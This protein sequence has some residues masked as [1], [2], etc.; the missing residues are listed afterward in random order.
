MNTDQW[1]GPGEYHM[2]RSASDSATLLAGVCRHERQERAVMGAAAEPAG[3]ERDPGRPHWVGARP[4]HPGQMAF[5]VP[6]PPPPS[7]RLW[8]RSTL[9]L[10]SSLFF[11]S[12][13]LSFLL[14]ISV[15]IAYLSWC[16]HVFSL[17]FS[18]PFF[19][20]SISAGTAHL[21]CCYAARGISCSQ[22]SPAFMTL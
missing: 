22:T 18:A 13:H 21:S 9:C 16:H 17:N 8:N 6:P 11:T 3:G 15:D 7:F 10:V 1:H 5:Q 2:Y 12:S 19:L 14:D 20:L 4:C